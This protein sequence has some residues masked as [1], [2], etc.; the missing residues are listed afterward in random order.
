MSR[1]KVRVR[2]RGQG[3]DQ[4]SGLE[5]RAVSD[6]T[7]GAEVGVKVKGQSQGRGER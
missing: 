3:Q 4:K 7:V 6:V 1:W 2:V 5:I